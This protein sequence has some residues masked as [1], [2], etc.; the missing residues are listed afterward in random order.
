MLAAVGVPILGGGDITYTNSDP[1]YFYLKSCSLFGKVNLNSYCVP[2]VQSLGVAEP[3]KKRYKLIFFSI[4]HQ[5]AQKPP[6]DGF[7][8]MW[9]RGSSSGRNQLCRLFC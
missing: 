2:I 7:Y 8:Q 3:Q 9:Y 5:Y 4:F 1:T 6:V